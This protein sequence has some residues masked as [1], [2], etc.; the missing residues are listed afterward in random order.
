[1]R[2]HFHRYREIL[3]TTLMYDQIKKR[4]MNEMFTGVG[5]KNTAIFLGKIHNATNIWSFIGFSR[6]ALKRFTQIDDL[7]WRFCSMLIWN[8]GW[9]P[10]WKKSSIEFFFRMKINLLRFEWMDRVCNHQI[11]I[12][13]RAWKQSSL[14]IF[15]SRMKFTLAYE[16]CRKYGNGM[17][18]FRCSCLC[19]YRDLLALVYVHLED[20]HR[21]AQI[22]V[23]LSLY[24]E[25]KWT[26]WSD[27]S[28]IVD[29]R[30]HCWCLGLYSVRHDR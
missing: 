18:N 12:R 5:L 4:R 17:K 14:Q 27:S 22:R 21:L 1:M 3:S 9:H 19:T 20:D 10:H 26:N 16:V 23:I 29:R 11:N 15:F 13:W 6:I 2:D 7:P 25:L 24:A 8:L 28:I 30:T